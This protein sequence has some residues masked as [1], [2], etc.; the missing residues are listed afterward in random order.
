MVWRPAGRRRGGRVRGA[1]FPVA[2]TEQLCFRSASVQSTA[3]CCR[4]A[5]ACR[6]ALVLHAK[7]AIL[8]Y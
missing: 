1:V 8:P 2:P 5:N 6:N 3:E 4:A 7:L